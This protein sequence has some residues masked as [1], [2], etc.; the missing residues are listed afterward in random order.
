MIVERDGLPAS[1]S[2][3]Y[4]R[5]LQTASHAALQRGRRPFDEIQLV[6]RM[7]HDGTTPIMIMIE[8]EVRVVNLIGTHLR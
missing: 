7:A 5:N 1:T 6:H 3:V 4:M 8:D 2:G